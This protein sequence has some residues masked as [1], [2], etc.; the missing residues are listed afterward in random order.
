MESIQEHTIR[1]KQLLREAMAKLQNLQYHLRLVGEE[2]CQMPYEN[3]VI[4]YSQGKDDL[5]RYTLSSC[6]SYVITPMCTP[7]SGNRKFMHTQFYTGFFARGGRS[8]LP[9]TSFSHISHNI[10]YY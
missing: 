10:I 5:E 1:Q 4:P 8:G 2:S 3:Q 6:A 7:I 9:Y